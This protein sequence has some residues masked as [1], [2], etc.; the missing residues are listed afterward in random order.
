MPLSLDGNGAIGGLIAG[1]LPDATVATNDLVDAAV[2]PTKLSQPLTLMTA[3]NAT[4][5][6]ID[7]VGI[8]SWAKRITVMF[9]GVSTNG[10]S[11]IQVQIGTGASP[12]A[13]GYVAAASQA[14]STINTGQ[15]T[16]GFA[17][18][19][20]NTAAS[21]YYGKGEIVVLNPSTN[22]Y[23]WAHSAHQGAGTTT[24]GS[25]QKSLAGPIGI[26]RITTVNGTD[27]FDAGSI[28]VMYEG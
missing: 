5:T 13:T 3:Q 1:G 12:D 23:V 10:T 2:T 6:S 9:N 7:F 15:F 24:Y 14:A 4:G 28:N 16:S 25:G 21:A 11:V 18:S 17:L 20:S 8:P 26:V 27:A 22:T 19:N